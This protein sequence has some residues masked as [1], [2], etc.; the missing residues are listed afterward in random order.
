MRWARAVLVVSLIVSLLG[1]VA[2][3]ETTKVVTLGANLSVSQQ[4]EM[5]D[6][7]GVS[8]ADPDIKLLKVTNQEERKYLEGLA[9][10][11]QIGTRAI[12]C[13]YVRI[14][15]S[16]EGVDVEI[17]NITWVTE[18]A[19]ANALVTAGVKDARVVA[20]APFPVS[21]TAALT[22]LFKAYEEAEGEEIPEEAK[23]VA[24]EELVT[25]GE[26]GEETGQKE[27]VS[28]LIQKVKEEVLS[29][30]L[31]DP[32]DIRETIKRIA[33]EVGIK[34]SEAQIDKIVALMQKIGKLDI[35]VNQ[36][37]KQLSKWSKF[38]QSEKAQSVWE[39]IKNFFTNLFEQIESWFK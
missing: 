39:Q 19:Y 11:K 37:K 17:H 8:R 28:Q 29:K 27:K 26:L 1:G 32:E 16:G 12:S 15:S 3:G 34:L 13:V 20:A 33:E 10:E 2:W 9:P 22:G 4:D 35:D 7:F 24:T 14:L 23:K 38:F 18:Q 25:T 5:L 21:G 31:T 6:I 30:N 36:L